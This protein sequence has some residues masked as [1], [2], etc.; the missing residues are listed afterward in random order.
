[1]EYGYVNSGG[2]EA[3]IAELKHRFAAYL[4]TKEMMKS[5]KNL[6]LFIA[7]KHFKGEIIFKEGFNEKM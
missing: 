6:S 4:E 7:L 5:C 2:Q 3:I 1:M